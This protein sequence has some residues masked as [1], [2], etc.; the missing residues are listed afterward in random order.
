PSTLSYK[1]INDNQDLVIINIEKIEIWIRDKNSLIELVVN[2]NGVIGDIYRKSSEKILDLINSYYKNLFKNILNNE[3][4]DSNSSIP[5]PIFIKD[6]YDNLDN[7]LLVKDNIN[8]TKIFSKFMLEISNAKFDYQQMSEIA[9]TANDTDTLSKFWLEF[10]KVAIKK[11]YHHL[12]HQISYKIINDADMFSKFGLKLLEIAIQEKYDNIL[13]P[14]MDNIVKQI[15]DKIIKSI[16]IDL[17]I[18]FEEIPSPL[19]TNCSYMITLLPFISLNFLNLCESHSDLI[20]KYISYTSIIL[21]PYYDSYI[22]STNT[23]LYSY[24]FDIYIKKSNP[25]NDFLS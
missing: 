13:H 22:S 19:K 1:L 18:Q 4:N 16:Q 6:N 3:F 14:V 21:S 8:D 17:T 2:N 5:F 20:I 7:Y 9:F 25:V 15:I 10:L 23:S 24:S 11:Q 12:V